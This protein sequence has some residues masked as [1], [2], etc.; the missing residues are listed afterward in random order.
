MSNDDPD[1]S[2]LQIND[3]ELDR[4]C[5]HLPSQYGRAAFNSAETGRDIDELKAEL[6]V[7]EAEKA[8]SI[9][10]DPER[11]GL[12]KLTEGV[13][14]ELI[15]MDPKVIKLQ[16]QIRELDHKLA[17]EKALLAALDVK[18]HSLKNLVE[19]H[20]AGYHSEVRPSAGAKEFLDRKG[21]DRISKPLEWKKKKK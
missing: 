16:K 14:K 10:K 21:R 11:F 17:M 7:V 1:I 13:I 18:K 8:V 20:I 5:V 4:E 19:L 2:I 3:L 15:I 12:E 9:R 6:D